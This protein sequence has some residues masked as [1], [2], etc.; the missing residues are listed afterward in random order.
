MSLSFDARGARL[1][2]QITGQN[3]KKRLAIVLD[4]NV[5]SA[6]VIQD[7]ISGGRAQIT[8]RFTTDEARDLAIVLRAGALPAPVTII[9]ER[10]VGPSLG[11]DSI[12][13]G[14]KSMIIGG[15]V[16]VIFM[17]IYYG[18]SGIIADLALV[19]NILIIMAGLAFFGA[20][21]TLPGIAGIILTIGMS[22][23]A[24]VLIFERVREEMRLGKPPRASIE[25]GYGKALITILDA[26]V[27]TLI[28][29]L[30]LFQF[31]TGPVRGFAV[32]V[33][34]GIVAGLFTAIFGTRI[35]FDYLYV[36]RR[37]KRLSI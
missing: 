34:I 16:V 9:E 8:G 5:Y 27:T 2:E 10:T 32:T 30:V 31:G 4:N 13:K 28:A 14:F 22:V 33:S 20:T 11:K 37:M 6:P 1:F 26:Q 3:I 36:K 21:L 29:A 25:G 23:D 24:N 12:E 19:L 15:L 35:V 17:V 7:K 18:L